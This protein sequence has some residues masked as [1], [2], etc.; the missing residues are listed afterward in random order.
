MNN[1]KNKHIIY[2]INPSFKI[3]KY[4]DDLTED[5]EEYIEVSE[6]DHLLTKEIINSGSDK[7]KYRLDIVRLYQSYVCPTVN[8]CSSCGSEIINAWRNYL[9]A[10]NKK[11][12]T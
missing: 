6:E 7:S 5:L 8:I 3:V 11:Y 12:N 1:N 9:D 10:Y 2:Y 4:R